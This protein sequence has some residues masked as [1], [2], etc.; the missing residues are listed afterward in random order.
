MKYKF[1]L[2]AIIFSSAF[3]NAFA[4]NNTEATNDIG[5]IVLHTY[6]SDKASMP[7][8]AKSQLET[9][10]TQIASQY[11]MG[12]NSYNPRFIITANINVLTKDIVAGPPQMVAQNLEIVL[13]IGD[14]ITNTVFAN[15]SLNLKGVGTNET[16]AFIEA[17]KTLNPTNEHIKSFVENGKNKILEYYNTQCDFII[18]EAQTLQSQDKYEEAIYKL[19]QVPEV[20]KTC[21]D[22]CMDAIKPIYLSMIN[23]E[24]RKKLNEAKLKW[25]ANQN[26]EGA[27]EAALVLA[28]INPDASCYKEAENLAEAISIK[29]KADEQKK[30]DF[31]MQKYN[32]KIS[33]DKLRIDSYRQIALAYAKNLQPTII[34]NRII[35]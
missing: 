13:F 33:L 10:L 12:G 15:T 5:R 29:I 19:T 34:Y 7:Q 16:K 31:K 24:C 4:Q 21:Y 35:W 14:A 23:R 6:L 11:G 22:K 32:D 28:T 8:E 30:W 2:V 1:L 25:N 27:N 9:K 20:C 18:M 3:Y 17:I 26:I